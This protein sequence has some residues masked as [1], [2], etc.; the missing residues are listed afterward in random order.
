MRQPRAIAVFAAQRR[1]SRFKTGSAP[2]WPRQT[3]QVR[4]LGGAP[5]LTAQPQKSF[6]A[7]R[8]WT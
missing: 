8:S 2:G 3:G 7:V 6:V 4:L 5:N 1:A